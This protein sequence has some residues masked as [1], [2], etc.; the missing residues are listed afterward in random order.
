MKMLT[1]IFAAFL[2]MA[3][4]ALAIP[5]GQS[6]A[7]KDFSF[8][9]TYGGANCNKVSDNT[10]GICRSLKYSTEDG[11]IKV[12]LCHKDDLRYEMYRVKYPTQKDFSVCTA[13]GAG[14]V[15]KNW[16]YDSFTT[17]EF[18]FTPSPTDY[19]YNDISGFSVACAAPECHVVSDNVVGTCRTVH[20]DSS[21]GPGELLACHKGDSRYEVYSVSGNYQKSFGPGFVT[22]EKGYDSFEITCNGGH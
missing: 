16:G 20:F 12:L 2:F 4:A 7:V 15:D 10:T 17:Q 8:T 18:T 13:G 14:C 21:L 5:V 22:G 19:C 1:A 3:T 6:P 9:C 11:P